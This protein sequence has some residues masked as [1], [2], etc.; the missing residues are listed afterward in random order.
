[1][2]GCLLLN[3]CPFRKVEDSWNAR[4]TF[5]EQFQAEAEA[6]WMSVVSTMT[7]REAGTPNQLMGSF[8]ARG[9]TTVR[10][11]HKHDKL[12]TADHSP[13]LMACG[14]GNVPLTLPQTQ[15]IHN[16]APSSANQR[17]P[18]RPF[19]THLPRPSESLSVFCFRNLLNNWHAIARV[20]HT[21]TKHTF[22][23]V[24]ERYCPAYQ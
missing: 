5:K 13:S 8:F 20:A 16:E 17:Q 15:I 9:D 4:R 6:G 21:L 19:L 7:G 2:R 18:F 10:M 23:V 22:G 12:A 3:R 11:S 24:L 1:M 14:G